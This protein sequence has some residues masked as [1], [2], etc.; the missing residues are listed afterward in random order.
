MYWVRRGGPRPPRGRRRRSGAPTPP[1][2]RRRAA[3]WCAGPPGLGAAVRAGRTPERKGA[4]K[5]FGSAEVTAPQRTA[6]TK[7]PSVS[8]SSNEDASIVSGRPRSGTIEVPTSSSQTTVSSSPMRSSASD[9]NATRC[10]R[11]ARA[12]SAGLRDRPCSRTSVTAQVAPRT[13]T[14]WPGSGTETGPVGVDVLSCSVVIASLG[15][16]RTVAVRRRHPIG[17][18]RHH[19]ASSGVARAT[20]SVS[21][22]WRTGRH[23]VAGCRGP[24][25]DRGPQRHCGSGKLPTTPRSMCNPSGTPSASR[26]STTG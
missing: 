13:W 18:V 22:G 3:D 20:Q 6:S 19:G 16:V 4:W 25:Q 9:C 8:G 7:A 12:S 1:C 11:P 14:T 17:R 2:R 10:S 23:Q 5:A 21:R 24:A 26:V 15:L